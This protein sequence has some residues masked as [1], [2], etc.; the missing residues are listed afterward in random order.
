[1]LLAAL[2]VCHIHGN[3][4][5]MLVPLPEKAVLNMEIFDAC[6]YEK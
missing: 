2:V 1:M 3:K 5:G 6:E 4:S